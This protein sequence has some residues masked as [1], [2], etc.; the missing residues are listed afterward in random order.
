MIHTHD[1]NITIQ[2]YQQYNYILHYHFIL[3][4]KKTND[5]THPHYKISNHSNK[6]IKKNIK[7]NN[8]R[9]SHDTYP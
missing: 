2:I 4:K 5:K 9:N 1:K 8:K 3:K 7:P 6:K